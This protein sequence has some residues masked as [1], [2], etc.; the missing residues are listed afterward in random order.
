MASL[1]ADIYYDAFSYRRLS[2]HPLL[3]TTSTATVLNPELRDHQSITFAIINPELHDPYSRSTL[4][5]SLTLMSSS[6]DIIMSEPEDLPLNPLTESQISDIIDS[7]TTTTL[8]YT[9]SIILGKGPMG[10]QLKLWHVDT[11]KVCLDLCKS[12]LK[13]LTLSNKADI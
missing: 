2:T 9:P 7:T 13:V 11:S 10:T 3:P 6:Q 12:Q 4:A 8:S 5:R 1:A